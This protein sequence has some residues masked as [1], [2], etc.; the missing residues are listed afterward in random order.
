M[1]QLYVNTHSGTRPINAVLYTYMDKLLSVRE[2]VLIAIYCILVLVHVIRYK[3]DNYQKR[4]CALIFL[5][6]WNLI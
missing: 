2:Q 6:M 4:F 3:V 5:N 1:I